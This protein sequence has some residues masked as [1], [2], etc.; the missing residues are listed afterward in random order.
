MIIKEQT[1]TGI[2]Q[3]DEILSSAETP[4]AKIEKMLAY[5]DTQRRHAVALQNKVADWREEITTISK[6]VDDAMGKITQK[7]SEAATVQKWITMFQQ[8]LGESGEK[9]QEEL[10]EQED[11][12][13]KKSKKAKD[14]IFTPKWAQVKPFRLQ[15]FEK[16]LKSVF[17][18][19]SDLAESYK[20]R[21]KEI[22]LEGWVML[23]EKSDSVANLKD[24]IGSN[25]AY[26]ILY[27]AESYMNLP[28][29]QKAFV[30]HL[31]REWVKE[32]TS[33]QKFPE[34]TAFARGWL[35]LLSEDKELIEKL[36]IGGTINIK[37]VM[38]L[39]N[40]PQVGTFKKGEG[41]KI[42]RV[43]GPAIYPK[44]KEGNLRESYHQAVSDVKVLEIADWE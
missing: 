39:Q 12:K 8:L 40:K 4:S 34:G 16:I 32:M 42:V 18:Q 33:R 1:V 2:P 17:A 36:E 27:G 44:D 29:P 5:I 35:C 6:K 37:E 25:L 43:E 41:R 31:T 20:E 11:P 30:K 3:I 14:S 21:F 22:A 9:K 38:F 28:G 13:K 26:G 23:G 19:R 10:E 15:D 7:N 24:V